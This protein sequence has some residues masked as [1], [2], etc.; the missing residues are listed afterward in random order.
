LIP[1]TSLNEDGVIIGKLRHTLCSFPRIPLLG[2]L[3]VELILAV[4]NMVP[5]THVA[6]EPLKC[7]QSELTCVILVKSTL[8][9]EDLV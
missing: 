3:T 7:G 4:F 9:F 6:V 5:L 1:I 8:G 2:L